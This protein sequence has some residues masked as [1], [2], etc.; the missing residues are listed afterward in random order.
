MISITSR[1]KLAAF[2]LFKLEKNDKLV[3][4]GLM[5]PTNNS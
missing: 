4:E 5:L 3:I 1:E 2:F